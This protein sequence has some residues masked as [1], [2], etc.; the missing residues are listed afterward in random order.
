MAS[1]LPPSVTPPSPNEWPNTIREVTGITNAAQAQIT[2]VGHGFTSA[3]VGNT[4]VMFTR[5]RG[6][7]QI[8]GLPGKILG[9]DDA[10]HFTVDVNTTR[11]FTYIGGGYANI[12]AGLP[13]Y[14]PFQNIA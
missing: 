10:D 12:I 9:V 4:I 13:P 5:V 1:P 14:D 7:L 6:M 3:D 2:S 8:N 11:F